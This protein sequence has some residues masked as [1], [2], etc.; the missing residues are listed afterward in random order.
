MNPLV[1]GDYPKIMKENAGQRLPSFTE[2]E[3]EQVKGSFDFIGLNHY[4]S[5]YVKD[6]SNRLGPGL[7]DFNE[8]MFAII[9][10]PFSFFTG[11]RF[12]SHRMRVSLMPQCLLQLLGIRPMVGR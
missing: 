8:D 2:F 1:F 5:V 12:V 3:A 7:R 4:T 6:N 11:N 9:A 10:G